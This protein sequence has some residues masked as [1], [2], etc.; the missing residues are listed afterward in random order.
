MVET[1]PQNDGATNP[2]VPMSESGILRDLK[3]VNMTRRFSKNQQVMVIK[4]L[5]K[6][7]PFTSTISFTHIEQIHTITC[8]VCHATRKFDLNESV[9]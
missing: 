7:K 8:E 3:V 6:G 2:Q 1:F 5:V 4:C 9:E